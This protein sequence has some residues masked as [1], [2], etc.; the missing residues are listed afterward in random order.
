[1]SNK[2]KIVIDDIHTDAASTAMTTS[3]R[4][5]REIAAGAAPPKDEY[6]Y[7]MCKG[8]FA[9]PEAL[10]KWLLARGVSTLFWGTGKAKTIEL[11]EKDLTQALAKLDAMDGNQGA[12]S[13]KVK[14]LEA[15]LAANEEVDVPLMVNYII[16][17]SIQRGASDI[18][19]EPYS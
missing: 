15:Q 18:H 1:M 14:D 5:D 10:D 2:A 12:E 19:I 11:L 9:D 4:L 8:N 13:A 17:D 7:I 16:Q 6:E 3:Q